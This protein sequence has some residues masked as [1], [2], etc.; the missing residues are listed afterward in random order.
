MEVAV[1]LSSKGN[2]VYLDVGVWYDPEKGLIHM[3]AK[4]LNDFH[5]TISPD[6][7]NRRGH[8]NLYMKLARS[9]AKMGAPHPPIETAEEADD[10]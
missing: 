2:T 8:P 5:T 7:D 10:A 1:R 9:L 3:S 6:P 4:G